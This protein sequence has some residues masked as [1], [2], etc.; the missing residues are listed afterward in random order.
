MTKR[1]AAAARRFFVYQE[2]T[3]RPFDKRACSKNASRLKNSI[4][5]TC[6]NEFLLHATM[7]NQF[8]KSWNF[9]FTE[10]K[11]YCVLENG[12]AILDSVPSNDLYQNLF[13]LLLVECRFYWCYQFFSEDYSLFV[14][15]ILSSQTIF[16]RSWEDFWRL[17]WFAV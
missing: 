14:N 10:Q 7:R 17:N 11:Q 5:M 16:H 9:D 3:F 2:D 13:K 6:Q 15:Q 8:L 1:L 12:G 4:W